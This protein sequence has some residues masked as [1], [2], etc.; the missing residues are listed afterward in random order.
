MQITESTW[1]HLNSNNKKCKSK[2]VILIIYITM[3]SKK[4]IRRVEYNSE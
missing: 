3:E 1:I 4:N 2:L